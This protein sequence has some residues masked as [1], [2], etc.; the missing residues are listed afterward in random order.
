METGKK[1]ERRKL[2]RRMGVKRGRMEVKRRYGVCWTRIK[3][4]TGSL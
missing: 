4:T 1:S 2:Q 3:A